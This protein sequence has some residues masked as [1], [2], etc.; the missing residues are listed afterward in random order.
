MRSLMAEEFV[1]EL[2]AGGDHHIMHAFSAIFGEA[3]HGPP[4]PRQELVPGARPDAEC[5]HPC[6][7]G[8]QPFT[9]IFGI[10]GE[11]IRGLRAL[12]RRDPD[13]LATQDLD[14]AALARWYD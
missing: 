11:E 9:D 1:A 6:M 2:V 4:E 3:Q 5:R 7:V 12:G 13:R 14:G 8:G 10:V